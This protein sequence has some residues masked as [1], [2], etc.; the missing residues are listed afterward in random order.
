MSVVYVDAGKSNDCLYKCIL[1][2]VEVWI[3]CTLMC[4]IYNFR[5]VQLLHKYGY[6]LKTRTVEGQDTP[7]HIAARDGHFQMVK[8]LLS[9]GIDPE[10]M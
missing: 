9:Q 1:C 4:I 7:L 2:L 3:T 5:C 6:D 10:A 8:Y